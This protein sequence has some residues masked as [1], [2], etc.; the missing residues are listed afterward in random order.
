MARFCASLAMVR[1]LAFHGE[2]SRQIGRLVALHVRRWHE[3]DDDGED[4]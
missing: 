2:M 1:T 3:G 4:D